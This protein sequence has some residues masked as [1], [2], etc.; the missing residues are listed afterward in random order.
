MPSGLRIPPPY[1]SGLKAIAQLPVEA[2]GKLE[3]AL[4]EVP[5]SLT[6]ARLVEH[7]AD[8][9]PELADDAFDAFDALISLIALLPED[10]EGSTQL[11]RDVAYSEDLDL[12][13]DERTPFAERLSTLLNLECLLLAARAMDISTEHDRVFHDA[14]IFTDMRPVFGPDVSQGP[15]AALVMSTLKLDFHPDRAPIDSQF[16]ALDHGD[17]LRLRDVIQRAL[18]KHESLQKLIETTDLPYWE[19]KEVRDASAD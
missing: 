13:K 15:K 2:V 17:L 16:F 14:R 4:A 3:A 10:G 11:S 8:A 6:T 12:A 5:R 9:V 18:A 1:L 19:Y 7:I